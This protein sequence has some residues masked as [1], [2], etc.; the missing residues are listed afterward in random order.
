MLYLQVVINIPLNQTFEYTYEPQVKDLEFDALTNTIAGRRVWV[1]FGHQ[2]LLG[3]VI[4]VSKEPT[5]AKNKIKSIIDL[6]D[7]TPIFSTSMLKLLSWASSYYHYPIG[8]VI[9]S[10]VIPSLRK[11][12]KTSLK[13]V[14]GFVRIEDNKKLSSLNRSPACLKA[15]ELLKQGPLA[16]STLRD[17]GI[18]RTVINKL[19]TNGF[20]KSIDVRNN[21]CWTT[22]KIEVQNELPLNDEQNK[23]F[24][25]ITSHHNFGAFLLN[26]VTGSGKTEVYLH[27]IRYYLEKKKQALVLVPEI[28]LTPQTFNRFYSRFNVPVVSIHSSLNN[29]ERLES[30]LRIKNNEAAILIGTRSAIFSDIPNLG[31]IVIDE[32]HD[33]SYRQTDGF[34]YNCRDL[35]VMYAKQ[36]NIP[37]VLGTATPSIESF[38]NV[39]LGKF[40]ELKLTQRAGNASIPDIELIDLRKSVINTGISDTLLNATQIELD[41][42]NQVLFLLNRRGYAPKLVC[43]GCGH[44]FTCNQCSSNLFYHASNNVL[45]CHHCETIYPIPRYC[46][47]CGSAKLIA[48]G[49]GTEKLCEYLQNKFPNY[50]IARIDRDTTTKKG[51]IDKIFSEVLNEKYKI[52]VGTQ[53]LSKGHH[54]PNVTL[55]GILDID[56][57]LNSNDFR[58]TEYAAQLIT[59]VAGRAGRST[60]KGRVILQTYHP[61]H[62]FL[63][64]LLTYGYEGFALQCLN[65]RYNNG[66]PPF[67]AMAAIKTDSLVAHKTLSLLND[68]Y[69]YIEQ[70][71]THE[72]PMVQYSHPIKPYIEKRINRYHMFII[73]M[74]P[75]RV[76]LSKFL[77]KLYPKAEAL[78]KKIGNHLVFEIDPTDCF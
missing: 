63:N 33:S 54:F 17:R 18:S 46:P 51:S 39:K 29:T 15:L 14:E 6:I 40:K 8:E 71:L 34:L 72:F 61:E 21:A 28:N 10:A 35:A 16:S 36:M 22:T 68:I 41:N 2:Q 20:I 38:H 13:V 31:I 37:I 76:L 5:F 1:P 27:L 7:S 75:T 53:I 77:E 59:Q 55:V 78:N 74:A 12:E 57:L 24:L 62:P 26:G 50:G 66:L 43:H 58:A 9:L 67:S 3:I 19:V 49:I 69:L 47:C 44:V 45:K 65:I 70:K 48:T 52:L 73:I 60:K 23:A 42:G 11:G 32:E 4:N 30:F 56:N 64:E 25:A